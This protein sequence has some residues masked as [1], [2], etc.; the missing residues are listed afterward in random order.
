MG[1]AFTRKRTS[2]FEVTRDGLVHLSDL[3]STGDTSYA[4]LVFRGDEVLVCYYTSDIRKE[5]I[6]FTGLLS[7]SSIRMAGIDLNAMVKKADSTFNP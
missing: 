7:P 1:S 5:F 4:G 3:P 6:W 2:L